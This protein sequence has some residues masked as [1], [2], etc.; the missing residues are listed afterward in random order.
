MRMDRQA[1]DTRLEMD[2]WDRDSEVGELVENEAS[3]G[4]KS[5]YSVGAEEVDVCG[6]GGLS[7]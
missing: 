5:R 4:K 1:R 7:G 6:E 3:D 2:D